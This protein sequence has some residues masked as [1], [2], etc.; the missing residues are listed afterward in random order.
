MQNEEYR[1]EQ[2]SENNAI[3]IVKI[4]VL[5]IVNTIMIMG[6]QFIYTMIINKEA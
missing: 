4:M 6:Y 1:T 5:T 3:T 2:K